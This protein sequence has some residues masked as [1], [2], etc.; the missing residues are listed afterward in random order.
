[1]FKELACS[2][3]GLFKCPWTW[4]WLEACLKLL[5]RGQEKYESRGAKLNRNEISPNRGKI[6]KE[7]QNRNWGM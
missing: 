4:T 6:V 7:I 5:E 3:L 1:M 2:S